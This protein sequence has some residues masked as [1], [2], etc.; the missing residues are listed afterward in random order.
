MFKPQKPKKYSKIWKINR[1]KIKTKK[2]CNYIKH[3][4]WNEK[5][6]GNKIHRKSNNDI[7]NLCIG[8]R[9]KIHIEANFL[10]GHC[11]AISAILD[12]I[13]IQFSILN[14]NMQS[15]AH[16]VVLLFSDIMRLIMEK[17]KHIWPR[18]YMILTL[19]LKPPDCGAY[20]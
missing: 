4:R 10:T 6:F 17:Y 19:T 18:V 9:K 7:W 13:S 16:Y 3:N 5:H 14:S 1:S 12:S 20:F 8:S 15:E 11:Y 2:I